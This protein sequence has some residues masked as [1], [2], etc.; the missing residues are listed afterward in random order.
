MNIDLLGHFTPAE[1]PGTAALVA[2]GCLIGLCL[3]G[4]AQ[5]APV[6]VLLL[7][8]GVLGMLA[9]GEGW[10]EPVRLAIDLTYLALAAGVAVALLLPRVPVSDAAG[11]A[12]ERR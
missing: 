10:P 11:R 2:I 5:L 1:L 12:R 8:F 6:L 9:D 7:S 4:R 3:M